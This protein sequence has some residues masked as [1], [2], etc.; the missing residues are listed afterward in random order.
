MR[1]VIDFGNARAKDSGTSKFRSGDPQQSGST[2]R[3]LDG[4]RPADRRL[5]LPFGRF[6]GFAGSQRPEG[7]GKIGG[8]NRAENAKNQSSR[9]LGAPQRGREPIELAGPVLHDCEPRLKFRSQCDSRRPAGRPATWN[10][11]RLVFGRWRGNLWRNREES[12]FPS[13]PRRLGHWYQPRRFPTDQRRTRSALPAFPSSAE[14]AEHL[15]RIAE[16]A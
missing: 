14:W 6:F 9:L 8:Q 1:A 13:E 16:P 3:L 4:N 5:F 12:A 2:R 7:A 10:R 15:P 11:G